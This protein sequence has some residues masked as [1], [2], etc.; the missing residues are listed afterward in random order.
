MP[1]FGRRGEVGELPS[2]EEYVAE[3]IEREG[4]E[5][6]YGDDQEGP[7]DR[8]GVEPAARRRAPSATASARATAR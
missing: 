8:M 6:R 4:L 1:D 5:P 2:Y 7:G 3:L